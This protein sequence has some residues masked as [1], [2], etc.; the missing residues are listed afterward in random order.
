MKTVFNPI[1]YL[2]FFYATSVLAQSASTKKD[3]EKFEFTLN[4]TLKPT[5]ELNPYQEEEEKKAKEPKKRKKKVFYGLKTRKRFTKSMSQGKVV[6]E[7]FYVLKDY[8]E[9]DHKL[10]HKFYYHK[11][12]R[13]LVDE[14]KIDKPNAEIAHGPYKKYVNGELVEEGIYYIGSQHGRWIKYADDLLIWEK[15]RYY[16]GTPRDAQITYYDKASRKI[17]EIIPIHNDIKDGEYYYYFESGRIAIKGLYRNNVKIGRWY[18]YYD[19]DQKPRK[20]EVQNARNPSEVNFE[21]Y[22]I[23]EWNEDGQLIIDNSKKR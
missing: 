6:I 20:R 15:K 3:K 12:K 13:A 5:L 18:E 1:L 23:K 4:E 2:L 21:S 19:R 16:K 8:K 17:K 10:D 22:I 11:Q 14:K 7:K 9:P